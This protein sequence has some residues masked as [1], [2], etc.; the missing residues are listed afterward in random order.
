[1][2]K[3]TRPRGCFSVAIPND[4]SRSLK[5][6]QAGIFKQTAQ[7]IHGEDLIMD[8]IF[9]ISNQN[10]FHCLRRAFTQGAALVLRQLPQGAVQGCLSAFSTLAED[11]SD[12]LLRL[13]A[14]GVVRP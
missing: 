7:D 12:C 8:L 11:L 5:P 9:N 13:V 10:L 14:E 2:A 3:I 1:M 6:A 4:R